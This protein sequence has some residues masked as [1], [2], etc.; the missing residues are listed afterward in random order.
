MSTPPT[1]ALTLLR[2]QQELADAV[3]SSP[4]GRGLWVTAEL[5]DVRSSGGHCYMELVEKNA[6]GATVAKM[7]AAIWANRFPLLRRKFID[8]TG[9]DIS[10]G[11][12]VMVGGAATHHPVYGLSFIVSDID[13][14]YTMGDIERLRR[15]ILARLHAEGVLGANRALPLSPAPQRIAVISAP[16]AAGWG[17]FI[18]HLTANE[19]GFA[20]YPVLFPAAMQGVQT[21]ASVRAAL[22]RIEESID[23][24]DCVAILRGGGATTDLNGFDDYELARAVATFPLP[25]IVGIGHERD[26]TVLDEIAH[27]RVKTPTAAATFLVDSARRTLSTVHNL[28]LAAARFSADRLAG[29]QRRLAQAET[30][31]PALVRLRLTSAHAALDAITRTLPSLASGRITSASTLLDAHTRMLRSLAAQ[32]I[33]RQRARLDADSRLLSALSPAD[34]LRRGYSIT[35]VNGRAVTDPAA[36]RPGDTVETTLASGTFLSTPLAGGSGRS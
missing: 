18:N 7:R 1:H 5:S 20:F 25:V 26:R 11:I 23:V 21:S 29:E 34:T 10:T 16:G 6:A 12:K 2:L 35:R 19:E 33:E 14:S 30:S 15:E 13:P 8:A 27:T 36:V 31:L 3:S 9:R 22:E 4:A 24:W 17:D 32:A 28:A